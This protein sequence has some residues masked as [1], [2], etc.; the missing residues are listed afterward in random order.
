MK[1]Q[2]GL[3]FPKVKTDPS[4]NIWGTFSHLIFGVRLLIG[5]RDYMG[6]VHDFFGEG[7]SNPQAPTIH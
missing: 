5:R 7:T 1:H 3:N 4:F 6:L 2:I